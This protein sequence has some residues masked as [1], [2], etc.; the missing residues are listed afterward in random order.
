VTSADVPLVPLAAVDSA[1]SRALGSGH[2]AVADARALAGRAFDV[3]WV[4]RAASAYGARLDELRSLLDDVARLLDVAVASARS[5]ES[6]ARAGTAPQ[7]VA[8]DGWAGSE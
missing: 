4:S 6:L 1:A 2:V 3:D 5:A 8:A 7:C